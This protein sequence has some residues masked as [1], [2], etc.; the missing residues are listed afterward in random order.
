[1]C[2][3]ISSEDVTLYSEDLHDMSSEV[4]T[5]NKP[6]CAESQQGNYQSLIFKHHIRQTFGHGRF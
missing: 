6:R 5:K 3:T 4:K 2:Q 1:M